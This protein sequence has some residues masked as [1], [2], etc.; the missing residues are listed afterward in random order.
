[1]ENKT[2]DDMRLR[3]NY[4]NRGYHVFVNNF[5]TSIPLVQYLYCLQIY[6]TGTVRAHR[7]FLSEYFRNK[8][9]VGELKYFRN[10]TILTYRE[11]KIAK[12]TSTSYFKSHFCYKPERRDIKKTLSC[13]RNY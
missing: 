1:M 13:K 8:F 4:L 7:T 10:N 12:E 3:D 9:L 5:F 11:K 6:V 2:V